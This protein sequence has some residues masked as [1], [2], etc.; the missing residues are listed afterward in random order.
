MAILLIIFLKNFL[1]ANPNV[2]SVKFFP[3]LIKYRTEFD[4]LQG[5][6]N[7]ALRAKTKELKEIVKDFS[8]AGR[9]RNCLHQG[10]DRRGKP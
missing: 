3:W 10:R 2:I 9:G 7:D 4:L 6:S 5:I 8:K 1:A